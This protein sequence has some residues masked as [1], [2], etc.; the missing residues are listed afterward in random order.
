MKK[1]GFTIFFA[2]LVASLAVGVG[3][4]IYDLTVREID[5]S[6]TATQSQYA[7]YASDTGAECALYW[8]SH[9]GG[10]SNGSNSAFATSSSYTGA[11]ASAGIRCSSSADGLT[12]QDITTQ[13]P[14][15]ADTG[16]GRYY[17]ASCTTSAWCQ[18]TNSVAATTTFMITFPPQ[19]YCAVVQVAKVTRGGVLFSTVTSRGYNT[20]SGSGSARL[21]RTLQVTY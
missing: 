6:F 4:A 3:L 9:Y 14:P 17:S 15:T 16:V 19:S 20:C 12:G 1:R 7:I 18:E 8:D 5:L 10:A 13:G 11:P 21:E 2:M